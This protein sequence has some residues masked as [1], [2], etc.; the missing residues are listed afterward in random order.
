MSYRKETHVFSV[1]SCCARHDVGLK[2]YFK[3]LIPMLVA[4]LCQ[5]SFHAFNEE[6]IRGG[7][8]WIPKKASNTFEAFEVVFME[9]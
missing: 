5:C 4:G 3:I 9:L 2:L 8:S 6:R 7:N 1:L